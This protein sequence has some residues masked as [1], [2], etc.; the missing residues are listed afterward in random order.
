MIPLNS[1]LSLLSLSNKLCLN[2]IDNEMAIPVDCQNGIL[3]TTECY[4]RLCW[5]GESITIH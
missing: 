5:Q 4:D 3:A 2:E 1:D